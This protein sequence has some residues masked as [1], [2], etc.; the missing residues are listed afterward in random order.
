LP[1]E[2]TFTGVI[3]IGRQI[4]KNVIKKDTVVSGHYAKLL[5]GQTLYAQ[6][7]GRAGKLCPAIT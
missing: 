1:L 7:Y 2:F 5:M 6:G 4:I 3:T